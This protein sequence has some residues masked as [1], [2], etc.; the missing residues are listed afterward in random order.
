MNKFNYIHLDVTKTLSSGQT[1]LWEEDPKIG[2]IGHFTDKIII[3]NNKKN[4]W[5]WQT[6]PDKDNFEFIES[7]FNLDY[8]FDESYLLNDSILT[9][10][11]DKYKGTH[12]LKQP[13][14]ETVLSFIL[15]SNKS[16]KAIKTSLNKLMKMQNKSIQTDFGDSLLFPSAEYI[17]LIEINKLA[18]SGSGYRTKYLKDAAFRLTSERLDLTQNSFKTRNKLKE[19]LGIGDKIADCI[20][21]FSVGH[22]DITPIDRWSERIIT[23]LYNQ[24]LPKKYED[25]RKW[26]KNKFNENTALAGQILFEYIR[27]ST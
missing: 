14:E 6:Y 3:L 4:K 25:K 1:F 21:T 16:I 13:L 17:N 24:E 5:F 26:F 11:Y 7:Y 19:F 22:K 8:V 2:Y 12:I 27:N 10:A 15:A 18:K 23:D 9:K 20:L